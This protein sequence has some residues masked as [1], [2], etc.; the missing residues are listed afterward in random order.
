VFAWV[1]EA[2]AALGLPSEHPDRTRSDR[3]ATYSCTLDRGNR[4]AV[5][6]WACSKLA[7]P[8]PRRDGVGGRAR[9]RTVA[10]RRHRARWVGLAGTAVEGLVVDGVIAGVGTWFVR[11]PHMA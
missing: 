10:A 8:W 11:A 3:I 4:L 2:R 9:H 6:M 1:V 7:R 5:V